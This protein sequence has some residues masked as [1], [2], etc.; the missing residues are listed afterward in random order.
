ME[1]INENYSTSG[2]TEDNT[3]GFS[4]DELDDINSELFRRL[5]SDELSGMPDKEREQ[6]ISEEILNRF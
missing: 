3:D 4:E 5:R 1:Q 6:A 2:L